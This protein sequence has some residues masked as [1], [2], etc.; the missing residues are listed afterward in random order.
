MGKRLKNELKQKD[1]VIIEA[2]R[3]NENKSNKRRVGYIL[4]V[5]KCSS[6]NIISNY[7]GSG[8]GGYGLNLI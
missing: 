5:S 7:Y 8:V 6:Q 3:K 1:Q 4:T 2:K